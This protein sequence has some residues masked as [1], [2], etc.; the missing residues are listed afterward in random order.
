MPNEHTVVSTVTI[1]DDGTVSIANLTPATLAE[2]EAG[3]VKA[4]DFV[5]GHQNNG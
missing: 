2:I 5:R 4:L 3:L 1:R